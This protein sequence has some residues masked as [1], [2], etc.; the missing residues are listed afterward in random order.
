MQQGDSFVNV[1]GL[2]YSGQA[3]SFGGEESKYITGHEVDIYIPCG[4]VE[5]KSQIVVTYTVQLHDTLSVI[6]ALLSAEVSGIEGM[7][8]R[9]LNQDP[10][11]IDVGWVLFI[12]ME[13]NGVL[14]S[15]E[16]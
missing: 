5:Q 15:K 11:F 9:I 8:R 16:G 2:I 10:G 12:P 4:C 1:S 13:K 7:N 14:N 6:A 3:W